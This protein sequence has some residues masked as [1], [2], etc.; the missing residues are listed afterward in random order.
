ML[1]AL[2]LGAREL[3]GLPTL[4]SAALPPVSAERISFPSKRLPTALHQK[5]LTDTDQTSTANTVQLLLDN[6]S[7]EAIE[8]SKEP[9]AS[10]VPQLA[11]ERQLRIRKPA[12][13]TEIPSSGVSARS[14]QSTPLTTRPQTT[15]TDVAAEIFICPLI[16]RFWLFLRDEQA[17]EARTAHHPRRDRYSGTGTGLILNVIVISRFLG[18]LA[19]MV[20][21]ARN[22]P[23]WLSVIAPDALE[24]AVTLGSRPLS[25]NEG[26]NENDDSTGI[27]SSD[28][29]KGKEAA[30]LTTALEL[31]LVVLDGCLDLDGGRALGL[32]HTA[33]LLGTMEWA[34]DVL[35]KLENGARILGGGGIQEMQLRRAAAGVVL[36]ADEL[37]SRWRRSMINLGGP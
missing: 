9:A 8:S 11:R 6:I 21:A 36:K 1:N 4:V 19:V 30:M 32:E 16:N 35:A 20:H 2:A 17:R 5:Y 18:A 26:E 31:A 33:L 22:A 7:R 37:S 14:R 10:Q 15:F 13:V 27:A 28:G 24:L 25:A 12:K 34:G 29:G 23:E 3:A